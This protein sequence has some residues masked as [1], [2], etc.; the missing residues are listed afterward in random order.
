MLLIVMAGHR[1]EQSS[2][3]FLKLIVFATVY[4]SLHLMPS[5]ETCF[6]HDDSLASSSLFG[7]SSPGFFSSAAWLSTSSHLCNKYVL[8]P[9]A[10]P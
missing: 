5:E 10:R 7:M 4:N 8:I 9:S 6:L 1:Q 2:C 3:L